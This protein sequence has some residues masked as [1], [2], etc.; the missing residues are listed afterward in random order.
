MPSEGHYNAMTRNA[1]A[2]NVMKVMSSEQQKF[3]G[4]RE[5]CYN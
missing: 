5:F 1:A 4:E 2:N 3:M